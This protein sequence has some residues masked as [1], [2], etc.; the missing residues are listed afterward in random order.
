MLPLV[1]LCSFHP[2]FCPFITNLCRISQI[3][4]GL[5]D[6]PYL[7]SINRCLHIIANNFIGGV[8]IKN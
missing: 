4:G 2:T 5:E 6:T 1:N 3:F 8:D 7:C